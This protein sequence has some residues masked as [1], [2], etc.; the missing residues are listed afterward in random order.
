ML[1]ISI[2]LKAGKDALVIASGVNVS[3][4]TIP[5]ILSHLKSPN[6]LFTL[7]SD[8]QADKVS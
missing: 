2:S 7:S 4:L 1:L 5:P 6:T 8:R 3:F